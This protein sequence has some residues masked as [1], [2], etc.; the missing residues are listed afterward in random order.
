MILLH[1]SLDL[2]F[3]NKII[4]PE[5]QI[6]KNKFTF[7]VGKSGCGK[8]TYLK[9]LN[10]TIIPES[11]TISYYGKNYQ[12]YPILD[13][14]K[15]ILLVP[16]EIFLLDST[17]RENF[18]FYYTSRGNQVPTDEEI[19][20]FLK[21]CCT[22]FKPSD[23]CT[24]M[25]GGERQRVFLAIFLSLASEAILLDEPTAALDDKTSVKLFKNLREY[26]NN[27]SI[28]V[29]CISH[30]SKLVEDFADNIIKL[31]ESKHE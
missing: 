25:S 27:S 8:S 18:D 20:K 28:T 26:C 10:R 15:K 13:Y 29:I 3:K 7:I 17:V 2:N 11:G 16:Q 1:S 4:Y 21:I 9:I 24:K 22:D 19:S 6:L 5:I 14:R 12:S 23:I 31:E 30:N